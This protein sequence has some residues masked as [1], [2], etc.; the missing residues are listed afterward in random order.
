MQLDP[1]DHVWVHVPQRSRFVNDVVDSV[2][3]ECK[4]HNPNKVVA[5]ALSTKRT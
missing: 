4:Q 3:L 1:A 5:T 2:T